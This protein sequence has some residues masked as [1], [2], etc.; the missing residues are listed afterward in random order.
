MKYELDEKYKLIKNE[1]LNSTSSNPIEIVNEIMNKEYV[2]IHGPEHHFLDGGAFM[3]AFYNSKGLKV[4]KEQL[5]ELELRAKKM[6]GAMCGQWGVCGAVASLGASLA[7]I[8][9]TGPLTDNDYYKDNMEYT[10]QVLEVMSKIGG[11]RCCKRNAFLAIS[12]VVKFVDRKYNVKMICN[13]IKCQYSHKNL[14]CIKENVHFTN[15][16][17]SQ[18]RDFICL[19]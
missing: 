17:I 19:I 15:K 13:D 7:I 8:N 11:P 12:L 3:T 14:Q 10:S 9:K 5:D 18:L 4:S 6:P 2:N 16:K 1:L